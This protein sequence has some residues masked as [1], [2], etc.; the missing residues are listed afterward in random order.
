MFGIKTYKELEKRANN[1]GDGDLDL[2]SLISKYMNVES[3]EIGDLSALKKGMTNRS[4][5]F[6]LDGDKYI[7]RIPGEGTD[8]LIDRKNEYDVYMAIRGSG[9]SDDVIYISPEDGYKISRFIQGSRVC[10]SSNPEEV[11]LCIEKLK[12]FHEMNLKVE[13]EFDIF[14]NINYYESLWKNQ[15]SIYSDYLETKEKVMS[16]KSIIES[17]PR[18]FVLSHIDPV[19]DN[20]LLT[21]GDIRLIDWEYSAMQDPHVD[22]AMFAI[23]SD[24]E[25]EAVDELIDMY[26]E[27]KCDQRTR[28]KI[29]CYIAACA[30]LWSNW[31]EYKRLC[32]V[33]FPEYAK[34]QYRYAKEYYKIVEHEIARGV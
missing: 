30:L 26:F 6:T 31:C 20:F 33:E 5:K 12:E 3:E 4:F 28:V 9:I 34:K 18:D 14:E 11:K 1:L 8:K 27:G 21:D 19:G 7:I 32:G 2:V 16:L 13:H 29:Y 25:R 23:Y 10:D 15:P 22:I 17:S 24:Y